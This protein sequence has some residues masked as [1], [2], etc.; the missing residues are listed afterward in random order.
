MIYTSAVC[1][2]LSQ[3]ATP[4]L[5]IP[6]GKQLLYFARV[7]ASS[8]VSFRENSIKYKVALKIVCARHQL[9]ASPASNRFGIR[10]AQSAVK[11]KSI[12]R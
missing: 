1:A 6:A 9:Y 2:Y 3:A 7:V 10:L 5:S 12:L 4:V 11:R 8:S